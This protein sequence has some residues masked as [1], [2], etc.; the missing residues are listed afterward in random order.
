[1]LKFVCAAVLAASVPAID[2]HSNVTS[3]PAEGPPTSSGPPHEGMDMK[4][5]VAR[6]Q[7]VLDVDDNDVVDIVEAADLVYIAEEAGYITHD[8]AKMFAYFVMKL[9]HLKGTEVSVK[10]AHD[11]IEDQLEDKTGIEKLVIL[12]ALEKCLSL[13]EWV[14]FM[15]GTVK[16]F[17]SIDQNDD[18]VLDM[19]E[20][21][22]RDMMYLLRKFDTDRSGSLDASEYGAYVGTR[23]ALDEGYYE[24]KVE[25]SAIQMDYFGD[26]H[27]GS[28][29]LASAFDGEWGD[30]EDDYENDDI[31]GKL[32]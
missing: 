2:L 10:E 19:D 21:A 15:H 24:R 8:E 7:E 5:R 16:S 17:F 31:E 11:A 12:S 13:A 26:L 25:D 14:F 22:D 20:L 6:L 27:M 1:M 23:A 32:D 28:E 18:Y 29:E 30:E 4:T 9:F 3:E